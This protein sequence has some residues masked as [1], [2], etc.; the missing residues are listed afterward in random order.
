MSSYK[1]RL[2]YKNWVHSHASSPLGSGLVVRFVVGLV[3]G[4]AVGP[5]VASGSGVVGGN[6]VIKSGFWH[7]FVSQYHSFVQIFDFI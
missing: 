7:V 5:T 1:N 2:L 6:V 3:V 4:S